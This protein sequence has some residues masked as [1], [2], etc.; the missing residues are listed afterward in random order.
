MANP[1]ELPMCTN[2]LTSP[3]DEDR[4]LLVEPN[5]SVSVMLKP[6]DLFPKSSNAV[7]PPQTTEPVVTAEKADTLVATCATISLASTKI[8]HQRTLL[9]QSG[10]TIRKITV[11]AGD[12]RDRTLATKPMG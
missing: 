6:K 2:S 10:V 3:K 4:L 11:T 7:E 12:N 5:K 1:P 9:R 8:Q